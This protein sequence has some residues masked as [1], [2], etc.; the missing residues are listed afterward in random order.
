[1]LLY[2]IIYISRYYDFPY[3]CFF[4]M[5]TRININSKFLI[6][7]VLVDP[8]CFI[9]S[10][11]V[12]INYL[13]F[14]CIGRYYTS[15]VERWWWYGGPF[16]ILTPICEKASNTL[17]G[18]VA[19]TKFMDWRTPPEKVRFTLKKSR[20]WLAKFIIKTSIYTGT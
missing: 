5:K 13:L 17:F 15:I 18:N 3:Y 7:I 9:V 12:L 16:W 6:C 19:E 4:F 10:Q 14:I 2:Y 11:C 20:E 1:M 8:F